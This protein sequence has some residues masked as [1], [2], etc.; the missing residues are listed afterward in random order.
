MSF[1]AYMIGGHLQSSSK[2][3]SVTFNKTI[4]QINLLQIKKLTSTKILRLCLR[5]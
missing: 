1:C 4:K 2:F 5:M 3:E